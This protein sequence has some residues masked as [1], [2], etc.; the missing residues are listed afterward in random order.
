MEIREAHKSTHGNSMN[1]VHKIPQYTTDLARLIR[2]SIDH[3]YAFFR[4]II[5]MSKSSH[6][7]SM[8]K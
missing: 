1:I 3:H 8:P 4:S 5:A 7:W 2:F 6:D